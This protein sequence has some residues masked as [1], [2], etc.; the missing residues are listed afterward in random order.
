MHIL[1]A[2]NATFDAINAAE[3]TICNES[4]PGITSVVSLPN[5]FL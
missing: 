2:P 1:V 5:R 3:N 4:S